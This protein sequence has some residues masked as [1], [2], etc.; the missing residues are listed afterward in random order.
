MTRQKKPQPYSYDPR[1]VDEVRVRLAYDWPS[2]RY[3]LNVTV[4]R[5]GEPLGETHTH[6]GL[7]VDDASDLVLAVFSSLARDGST[8]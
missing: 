4:K 5:H 6:D 2:G 8:L 3:R 1:P 7:D